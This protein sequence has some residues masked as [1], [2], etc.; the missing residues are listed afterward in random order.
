MKTLWALG[1]EKM[2]VLNTGF[3]FPLERGPNLEI[4]YYE[5]VRFHGYHYPPYAARL[6]DR[7]QIGSFVHDAL[8]PDVDRL[9]LPAFYHTR[10]ACVPVIKDLIQ[11]V[12]YGFWGEFYAHYFEP[13]AD[14]H[15]IATQA[16]VVNML[17]TSSRKFKDDNNRLGRQDFSS[18]WS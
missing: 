14:W 17:P 3:R 15:Q 8:Y 4:S 11:R 9:T 2:A 7:N 5:K 18:R 10:G 16:L 12:E 6:I 13:S 1:Y